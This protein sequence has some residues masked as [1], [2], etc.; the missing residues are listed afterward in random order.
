MAIEAIIKRRVQQGQQAKQLVPLLKG[1]FA[2]QGTAVLDIISPCVTFN[3]H[4]GSTK[5]YTWGKAHEEA[6]HQVGFVPHFEQIEVDYDEGSAMDV[7][8]HDGSHII[9]KKLDREYDPTDRHR[10]M[11]LLLDARINDQFLIMDVGVFLFVNST[12][13]FQKQAVRNLH[14]VGF[15]EN[16][17]LG[18]LATRCKAKCPARDSHAGGVCSDLHAHDDIVSHLIL[19]AAV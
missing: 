13:A 4:P 6:L 2:H 3:N 9:L 17:D 12:R 7:E 5:S 18:Q 14:D 1:A 8:L 16:R 11:Q 19:H 15:M 10:A